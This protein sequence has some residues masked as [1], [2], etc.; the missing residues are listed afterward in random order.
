VNVLIAEDN[1]AV[2]TH[3]VEGLSHAGFK[4]VLSEDGNQALEKARNTVFDVL[5]VDISMPEMDGFT[6]VK[7]LRREGNNTP[8]IFLTGFVDVR[9]RVHGLE[10]GGDDYLVKPFALEELIARIRA[11]VRR[12]RPELNNIVRMGDLELNLI[13]RGVIF[14]GQSVDLT[15]REFMLLET[16]VSNSPKPVAKTLL[17][18]TVWNQKFDPGTNVLN[19]H[20]KNLRDKLAVP[21]S[22]QIIHTVRHIGFA[23]YVNTSV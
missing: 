14:H 23:A 5:V 22:K 21:G 1:P 11:V 3:L 9:D 8:V 19:V 15:N 2:S 20:I 7:T 10:V 4:V 6:L 12:L 18:E 13:T 16:L 17:M